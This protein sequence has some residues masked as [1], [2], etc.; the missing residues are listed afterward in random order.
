V[1]SYERNKESVRSRFERGLVSSLDLRLVLS[2]LA[3]AR[4]LLENRREQYDRAVRQ[5]EIIL[6]RYPGGL[7][8]GGEQLPEVPGDIAAGLPAGLL[9]RRPD[10]IAAE[11][12][13]VAAEARVDEARALLYP[14]LSLTAGGG[15][16]SQELSDLLDGDFRVW[17]LVGNLFQPLFQGGRLRAGVDLA[18]ARVREAFEAYADV[19]LNALAEVESELAAE[20]FLAGREREL[21]I[22]TEQATAALK[23]AE[24]RYASGLEDI[25]TVLAA[26]RR[27]VEA[28]SAYLD[29]RRRR[30]D[31]RVDL[32][33][34]LGGGFEAS[35]GSP[36]DTLIVETPASGE[37][38]L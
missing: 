34:A 8:T 23:L 21:A 9:I 16:A 19:L 30:L 18:D 14:R 26:Q 38:S 12:R 15:T 36:Y 4:A 5:L 7:L 28:E 2:D 37:K 31:A 27:T 22:A 35:A 10:L 32:H 6:G 17:N 3:G 20:E 29:V 11:R 13:L 1:Q 25:I 33:L 24:E